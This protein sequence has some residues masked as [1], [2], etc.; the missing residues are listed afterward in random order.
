MM[1]DSLM[2]KCLAV[3]EKDGGSSPS[4]PAINELLHC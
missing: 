4:L 1:E 2:V 3:N